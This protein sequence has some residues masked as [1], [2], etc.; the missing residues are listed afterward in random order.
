MS[1]TPTDL[2]NFIEEYGDLTVGEALELNK[3][4]I[5]TCGLEYT[6]QIGD[7]NGWN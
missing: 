7:K 6:A 1:W 2:H 4:A 5:E 3:I